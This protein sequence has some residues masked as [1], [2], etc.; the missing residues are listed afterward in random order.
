MG[1]AQLFALSWTDL[2]V[3][4]PV[5]V[6]GV[7][8]VVVLTTAFIRWKNRPSFVPAP[9]VPVRP[10]AD[11]WDHLEKS[12]ADQR[13]SVRRDGPPVPVLVTSPNLRG[14][15][16]SGYVLDRSTGGLRIA[17]ET[18]MA[19]GSILQVKAENAPADTQWVTVVVRNCKPGSPHFEL[20]CEFETTPPWN[21]LL[22]FG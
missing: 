9:P 18:A 12:Y 21:V 7:V 15:A 22:L 17:M 19:P 10:E 20:G 11:A 5:V 6:G 8:A 2:E 3:Y 14:G 4:L 1:H 16:K 13:M